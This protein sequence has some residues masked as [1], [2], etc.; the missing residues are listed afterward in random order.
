MTLDFMK[1][2][3]NFKETFSSNPF[4]GYISPKGKL[5][6]YSNPL[7]IDTGD[8]FS[9]ENPAS[10]LFL[11]YISYIIKDSK[12]QDC[13]IKYNLPKE[14]VQYNSYPGI[15]EIVKRGGLSHEYYYNQ[16]SI[17]EFIKK[18]DDEIKEKENYRKKG[19]FKEKEYFEMEYDILRFFKNAY[20]NKLFFNSINKIIKVE[21][22]EKVIDNI[23]QIHSFNFIDS[24]DN[25]YRTYL[26]RELM[27][28]FKD[29]CVQYLGYDSIE[30]FKPDGNP[31]TISKFNY[32][33]YNKNE[34]LKRPRII[35]TSALNPNERFFNY[36]LMEWSV[37]ILPRYRYNDDNGIYE[38]ESSICLY[39]QKG[40][41]EIFEKEIASIK[42]LVPIEER[43]KYFR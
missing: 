4:I 27:D 40:K 6:D 2:E 34:F 21:N 37:H 19:S 1:D 23:G 25:R 20:K 36:L 13:D 8:H 17:D 28:F 15:E 33:D 41:E 43:Y 14:F 9:W 18:I 7:E 11:N 31:I 12:S 22:P 35:T 38:K 5:I 24:A 16:S 32:C 10:L 29:I 42:R 39:H 30:R 26:K 3:I